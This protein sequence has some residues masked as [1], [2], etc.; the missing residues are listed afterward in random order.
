MNRQKV[1]QMVPYAFGNLMV[2]NQIN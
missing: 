2:L 1:E